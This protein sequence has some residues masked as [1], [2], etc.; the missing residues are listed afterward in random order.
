M[1]SFHIIAEASGFAPF[2]SNDLFPKPGEALPRVDCLLKIGFAGKVRFLDPQKNP[3][4]NVKV[5]SCS[6]YKLIHNKGVLTRKV[7]DNHHLTSDENGVIEIP[8]C[9]DLKQYVDYVAPGFQHDNAVISLK[10]DDTRQLTL[11]PSK[12]SEGIVVSSVDQTPVANAELR[13]VEYYMPFM[14][15]PS[16]SSERSKFSIYTDDR[17][18]FRIPY[19]R[20]N[21]AY[22][23]AVI[24]PGYAWGV[25]DN[26]RA[27]LNDLRV[28]LHPP[29]T[30]KGEVR[31][32]PKSSWFREMHLLLPHLSTRRTRSIFEKKYSKNRGTGRRRSL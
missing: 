6:V 14:K 30:V 28:E 13:L 23:Y 2:L 11:Q 18:H 1:S 19:L 3:I 16:K 22:A 21:G 20:D 27:G 17:G 5:D 4:P 25:L 24:A 15:I 31:G 8:L 9:S 29:K 10:S 12:L 32:Q 7:G 26:V